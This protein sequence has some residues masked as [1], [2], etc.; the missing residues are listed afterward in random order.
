MECG[1]QSSQLMGLCPG[2]PQPKPLRDQIVD[3]LGSTVV[4]EEKIVKIVSIISSERIVIHELREALA[5]YEGRS[6]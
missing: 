6:Q 2:R 4:S 1:D 5:K 3:V